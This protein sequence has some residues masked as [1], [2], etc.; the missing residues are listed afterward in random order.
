MNSI[1][2]LNHGFNLKVVRNQDKLSSCKHV[3]IVPNSMVCMNVFSV[4]VAVLHVHHIG[5]MPINTS[6]RQYWCRLTGGLR[7]HVM[8]L[9]IN[10]W[11]S[12]MMRSSYIVVIRLWIVQ[13]FVQSIWTLVRP[14]LILRRSL[15]INKRQWV[16]FGLEYVECGICMLGGIGEFVELGCGMRVKLCKLDLRLRNICLLILL[17]ISS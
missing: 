14:L 1:V 13:R 11:R 7:I 10:D 5:G 4:H 15:R 3:K 8:I 16:G 17:D 9:L 6:D 12:W 2:L